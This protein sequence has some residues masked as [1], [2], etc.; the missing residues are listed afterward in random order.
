MSPY[1]RTSAAHAALGIALASAPA[2]AHG[3]LPV[4]IVTCGQ[5]I[6]TSI[7]VGNNLVDCPEHGLVVG[8]PDITIDL[9]GHRFSGL[10]GAFD[11]GVENSTG[12]DGVTVRNGV[13]AGFSHAVQFSDVEGGEISGIT[14][15]DS[16]NHGFLVTQSS[17]IAMV[18]N[19]AEGSVNNGIFYSG[20]TEGL[21]K[22]NL[23]IE[24][25]NTGIFVNNF[26]EE[27]VVVG[28]RS[29]GNG[30]W[31]IYLQSADANLVKRNVAIGNGAHGFAFVSARG[32]EVRSNVAAGN[33]EEGFFV[34]DMSDDNDFTANALTGNGT[35]GMSITNS[36]RNVFA[37]NRVVGNSAVGIS[38]SGGADNVL[39]RNPVSENGTTGILSDVNTL[40]LDSNF[41]NR[42]G[43]LNG[44]DDNVGLGIDVPLGTDNGG[45][46][47]LNNDD[48]SQ[49][50]AADV[51]CHVAP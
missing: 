44:V 37:A 28:N 32:N 21:L 7:R 12:F 33:D 47:A 27:I 15:L 4:Q 13:L 25:T 17:R 39:S 31:G 51:T 35:T 42:N 11:N 19:T 14:A 48:A 5:V 43:L 22:D 8:A 40:S 23:A 3:G 50:E 9:G 49:C 20:V 30:G 10:G 2:S 1:L 38:V 6:T 45:N 36:S 18:G 29:V 16:T 46:R 26:S 24:N 41:A 34:Y